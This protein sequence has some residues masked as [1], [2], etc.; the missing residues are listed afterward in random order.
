M[1]ARTGR[2][3]WAHGWYERYRPVGGEAGLLSARDREVWERAQ[4]LAQPKHRALARVHATGLRALAVTGAGHNRRPTPAAA[5]LVAD[6]LR[7]LPHTL[8]TK[9]ER[10]AAVETLLAT[11]LPALTPLPE[12]AG[13]T[14][15][16]LYKAH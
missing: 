6:H 1:S 15:G 14:A 9:N 11:H 8:A 10:L 12:P 4:V 3:A 16:A 7:R 2:G 13:R 5:V